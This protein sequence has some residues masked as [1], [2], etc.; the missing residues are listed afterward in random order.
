MENNVNRRFYT[1]AQLHQELEGVI[2]KGQVYRMIKKVKS[3]PDELAIKSSSRR[4]G[5]KTT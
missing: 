4:I 1:V 2:S 5:S 3:R